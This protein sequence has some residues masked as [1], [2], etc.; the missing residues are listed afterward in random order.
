M[1]SVFKFRV[2]KAGKVPADFENKF[3]VHT[4]PRSWEDLNVAE[5]SRMMIRKTLRGQALYASMVY[6]GFEF[7]AEKHKT[8]L[9]FLYCLTGS[10]TALFKAGVQNVFMARSMAC[11]RW[12]R[13]VIVMSDTAH[14]KK[15]GAIVKSVCTK[16]Y[17]A[18]KNRVLDLDALQPLFDPKSNR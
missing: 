12:F 13:L 15:T 18:G 16:H 3:S 11:S 17:G 6:Q 4:F 9:V 2:F 10:C 7:L 5:V 1:M 14:F 8:D